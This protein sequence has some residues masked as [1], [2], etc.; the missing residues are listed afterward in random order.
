MVQLQG[1]GRGCAVPVSP[2]WHRHTGLRVPLDYSHELVC[3]TAKEKIIV[4]I[5]AISARAILDFPDQLDFSVCPVKCSSQKTLLVR[6]AGN[7]E[8]RFQLSTQSPFS[9]VP[10]TGT[11]GAGDTMQVTVGF[12][13]LTNGDHFGSLC[14]NT[15]EEIFHTKLHGEAVG[16]NVVL[17]TSSVEVKTFITLSSQTTVFIENRSNITAH[18]Q[19]K[20][21]PTEEEDNEE[22][23]RQCRLLRLP[24]EVWQE[25][26]MEE[27]EIEKVKGSCEDRTALLNS[28]VQ[29]EMAKVQEDPMLFS[30]DFFFIEPMVKLINQGA[31]DAPF[32]YIPSTTDMGFCFKFAPEEGIIAPGGTQTVQI[33]FNAPMLGWFEEEF[34]FSVAGSPTPVILTIKLS[35]HAE[36]SPH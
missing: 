19:W 9:V 25:N 13:A 16:L 2:A 6:N 31:I 32:S 14:C 23:R 30:N 35:L 27:K 26:L 29:E 36:L 10:A 18:F 28:M 33:S 8:A 15:G 24:K 4:P 34:Q 3:L 5:R 11:L 20:A 21:F 12:H 1:Q 7:R 17:T 22:K